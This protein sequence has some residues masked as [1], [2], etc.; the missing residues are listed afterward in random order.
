MHKSPVQLIKLDRVLIPDLPCER[1]LG[2]FVTVLGRDADP[3][4][5]TGPGKVQV[6]GGSSTHHL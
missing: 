3:G 5:Q 4:I 6:D 2:H 1:S